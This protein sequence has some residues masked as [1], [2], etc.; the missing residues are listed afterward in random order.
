MW[1]MVLDLA[2]LFIAK[3]IDNALST[4]KT[5]LIQKNKWVLASIVLAVSNAIYFKIA[6]SIISDESD[7][8]LYIVAIA[9]GV[10]CGLAML[11]N[12]RFSKERTFVNV[13]MSD[14]I[15]AM[16]ALRTFLA[17]NKITNVA[18]DSYT[19]DWETKTLTI[20]AYAETK[21]ESKLIDEYLDNSNCK[22]KRLVN[23]KPMKKKERK[24]N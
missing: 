2:V 6:K 22:Y 7:L 12:N 14:D 4:T 20:T 13:I 9:S 23:D 10:G 24:G 18:A 16:K 1:I 15:E 17:E 5:I 21:H 8:A 11:V 19:L 3:L